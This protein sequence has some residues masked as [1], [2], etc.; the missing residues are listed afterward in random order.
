MSY[1]TLLYVSAAKTTRPAPPKPIVMLEESKVEG[2]EHERRLLV[3]M[4]VLVQSRIR[5]SPCQCAHER[6][7]N[8]GGD[9]T[10][11]IMFFCI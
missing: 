6:A 9:N 5:T 11:K 8:A 1:C 2:K 7:Q 10:A 3:D 4:P